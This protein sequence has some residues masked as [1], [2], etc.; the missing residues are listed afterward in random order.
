[1]SYHPWPSYGRVLFL[2]MSTRLLAVAWS[3]RER[4]VRCVADR[5]G[6]GLGMSGRSGPGVVICGCG[7][8]GRGVRRVVCRMRWFRRSCWSVGTAPRAQPGERVTGPRP[9]MTPPR[10]HLR[11]AHWHLYWTGP[12]SRSDPA[13]REARVRWIP[14]TLIAASGADDLIAVAHHPSSAVRHHSL[15]VDESDLVTSVT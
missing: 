3:R 2:S 14:P 9:V 4:R 13:K 10:A 5:W 7:W 11:R 6:S 1:M 15:S 12:G 8:S